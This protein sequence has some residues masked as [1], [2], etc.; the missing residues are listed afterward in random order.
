MSRVLVVKSL[1]EI[2][3]AQFAALR[4]LKVSEHQEVLGKSFLESITDWED[5]PKDEVLG[6]CFLLGG[7]PVGLTL[8][9]R[10]MKSLPQVVSIHGLKIATPWQGQGL[11]HLAFRL[12]V[13]HLIN[14]W[15]EAAILKL[16]VDAENAS[17]LA[18]Y[19]AFGMTDSGPVFEGPNGSEHRMEISLTR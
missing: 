6:L 17:A 2:T 19:R 4:A 7:E 10:P 5:A 9:K 1:N 11:G 16:A 12:A 3:A 18:I 14:A 13:D 8:F 15:P